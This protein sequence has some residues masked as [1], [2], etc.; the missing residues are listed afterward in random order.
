MRM[1]RG[2]VKEKVKG[3]IKVLLLDC[4]AFQQILG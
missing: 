4:H 3:P 1:T 2:N